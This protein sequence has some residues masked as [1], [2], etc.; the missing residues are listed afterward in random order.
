[1]KRIGEDHF[2]KLISENQE[3]ATTYSIVPQSDKTLFHS[4]V[5]VEHCSTLPQLMVSEVGCP[6]SRKSA[7]SFLALYFDF[8]ATS[9]LPFADP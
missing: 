4:N 9:H 5:G 1:M 2:E 6:S 8:A 7:L 3:L